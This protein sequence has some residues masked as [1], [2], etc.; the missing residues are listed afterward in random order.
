M[1]ECQTQ[2]GMDVF[3]GVVVETCFCKVFCGV[4]GTYYPEVFHMALREVVTYFCE[5]LGGE[6]VTYS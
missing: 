1:P 6:V 4:M 2:D 3:C 5:V